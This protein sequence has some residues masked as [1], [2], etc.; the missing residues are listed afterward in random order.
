MAHQADGVVQAAEEAAAGQGAAH[1][2]VPVEGHLGDSCMW[3][4]VVDRERCVTT[5]SRCQ[6]SACVT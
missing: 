4:G 3:D 6:H 1:V 2:R 5:R